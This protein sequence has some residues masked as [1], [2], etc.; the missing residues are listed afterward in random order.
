MKVV[1]VR[2]ETL[3]GTICMRAPSGLKGRGSK[4]Q[5]EALE[6]RTRSTIYP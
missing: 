5:G 2:R 4:A 3:E 1:I 6:I